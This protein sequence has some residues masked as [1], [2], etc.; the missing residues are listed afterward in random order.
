MFLFSID[1]CDKESYDV[2]IGTT[3]ELATD[4]GFKNII[5]SERRDLPNNI[6]HI[7][8]NYVLEPLTTYY[9]R[10][11]RHFEDSTQDEPTEYSE[12]M[13]D[14]GIYY[15]LCYNTENKVSV[16]WVRVNTD[17][18][19]DDEVEHFTVSTSKFKAK[20][21]GHVSTN[22]IIEDGAGKILFTSLGNTKDKTSIKIMK[23]A[24][25][26]NRNKLYFKVIHVGTE[27]VESEV[28]CF[29]I[30][31][32]KF[33]FEVISPLHDIKP[34]EDYQLLLRRATEGT[35]GVNMVQ[36][37]D[38]NDQVLYQKMAS[39]EDYNAEELGFI[40][41]W[42][43]MRHEE[44]V[45]VV[46]SGLDTQGYIGQRHVYLRTS[47]NNIRE[48]EDADYKYKNKLEQVSETYGKYYSDAVYS[49]EIPNGYIPLPENGKKGLYKYNYDSESGVLVKTG[50]E[51]KG[52]SLL[53]EDNNYTFI[54]YT[55]NNLLLVD[56]WRELGNGKREPVLLVYRHNKHGDVY[57]LISML[58]HPDGDTQTMST[59]NIV[60]ISPDEFLYI[61]N[62]LGKIFNL[63]IVKNTCEA[64][65]DLPHKG[66]EFSNNT[67]MF[68]LGNGRLYISG[69]T[70]PYSYMYD[71]SK[72]TFK[73]ITS[74][75]PA[76]FYNTTL[77][78]AY[79]IN[80]NVIVSKRVF[81]EGD[82]DSGVIIYDNVQRS[83]IDLGIKLKN[84]ETPNGAIT[85][86]NNDI[87]LTRRANGDTNSAGKDRFI[88][89]K[90]N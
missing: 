30:N 29:M 2:Q 43:L 62:K 37:L 74:Y 66:L 59:N 67:T 4:P 65:A 11:I 25:I 35:M 21:S 22:W 40:I 90:Y 1:E 49:I 38:D 20:E 44:S 31:Q 26:L 85:L 64:V 18:L 84:G 9:V 76:S 77:F 88:V 71:I 19:F 8:F 70:E 63:N 52:V 56:C 87:L 10:G 83:F 16:P 78:T 89:Y 15:R 48:V 86:L 17:E 6:L 82:N 57:N 13:S 27:N 14:S 3:F 34:A 39:V 32:E 80:G 51:L 7:V 33:N 53:S 5:F 41:P 75:E 28:G 45:H 36:V 12:V 46:I 23:T 73:T 81:V 42:Y 47:D 79:L 61:P 72:K 69:G 50:E 24:D 60:Q 55:E 68:K 54:K 58:R